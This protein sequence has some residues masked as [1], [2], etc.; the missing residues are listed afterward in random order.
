MKNTKQCWKKL[1]VIEQ[2]VLGS[3]G[4]VL[5]AGL[6]PLI[7][8]QVKCNINQILT[9]YFV[10]NDDLILKALYWQITRHLGGEKSKIWGLPV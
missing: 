1:K 9:K 10:E 7:E 3:S 2:E 6:S 8:I 5:R 4:T